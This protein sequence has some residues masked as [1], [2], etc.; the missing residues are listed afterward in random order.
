MPST[1]GKSCSKDG[2]SHV[3]LS[4]NSGLPN[5]PVKILE[6]I[7]SFL[8]LPSA[9]AFSISCFAVKQALG[10]AY[11]EL[12]N[13]PSEQGLIHRHNLLEL[14]SDD[15]DSVI[16]CFS[17]QKIHP[18]S[19]GRL[20]YPEDSSRNCVKSKEALELE[21]RLF[22]GFR[23][24]TMQMAM[25]LSRMG[26]DPTLYLRSMSV[27]ERDFEVW[28]N[29]SYLLYDPRIVGDEVIF[30]SQIWTLA[31]RQRLNEI[32]HHD[33]TEELLDSDFQ[34]C[35]HL[36]KET[37]ETQLCHASHLLGVTP[38]CGASSR[39]ACSRI[40]RCD[41]CNTEFQV[42]SKD[43]GSVGV[44]IIVTKWLN[45]GGAKT[46]RDPKIQALLDKNP[47]G[48]TSRSDGRILTMFEGCS[49][50]EFE[51]ILNHCD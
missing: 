23:F 24:T 44:A 10:T 47:N 3:R 4:Q 30:R 42:Q 1:D 20:R 26:K 51:P 17:C 32:Y 36:Y 33:Q 29:R 15:T 39:R 35:S 27:E 22:S 11:I 12:C 21:V 38:R 43:C 41:T 28:G 19:P 8:P 18:V 13:G 25:K 34:I 5:L 37:R 2:T 49:P 45:M 48:R 40:R 50:D 7:A 6:R 14:L 9:A 31:S 16:A 46:P